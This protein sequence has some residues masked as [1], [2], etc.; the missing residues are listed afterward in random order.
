MVMAKEAGL[1]GRRGNRREAGPHP[2]HVSPPPVQTV[3]L[4]TPPG[5]LHSLWPRLALAGYETP[6]LP[7]PP[8]G[9]AVTSTLR[10][11]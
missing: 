4:W 11:T 3:P 7:P 5:V 6:I 2:A 9:Q 10:L 8:A 1:T